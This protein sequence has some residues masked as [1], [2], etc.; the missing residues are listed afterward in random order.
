[1]RFYPTKIHQK[2][3]CFLL[4]SFLVLL[5]CTKDSDLLR[6]A[7]LSDSIE[8][9]EEV[10]ETDTEETVTEETVTEEEIV[11]ESIESRTTSFPPINDAHFQSG[12]GFN[13]SIIRLEEDSRTSYLMFDLSQIEA[14]DGVITAATLQF[15]INSDD[16]NGNITVHKGA[17]NDWTEENLVLSSIPASEEELGSITKEY[18]IGAT[19]GIELSASFLSTDINTLILDHKNGND[20]AI[21]SKEHSTASGPKLVVS[22]EVAPGAI[23]IVP[24]DEDEES[25]DETQEEVTAS[26]N[27]APM[28]IADGTPTTGK[29]PLEVSFT[30]GNSSDDSEVSSYTWNFK[31]GSSATTANPKHTFNEIGSY[32]V[33]L[34]VT[35][36]EGLTNTDTVLITVTDEENEAPVAVIS[37]NPKSGS[38]PLEVS[39]N[40][41]E[42]NDDN[43]ISSFEWDF[44]DGSTSNTTSPQHT[45]T[46]AGTY[47]VELTI[48]DEN[49]LADQ[50]DITITVTEPENEKPVAR[51]SANRTS[52]QAPLTVQFTGSNSTDDK[53][54][55]EYTWNFKN[56][57]NSAN[58]NPSHT[59][60]A[61]G[62][63]A[64]ALTV[65]DTEGLTDTKNITIT[66]SAATSNN[67]AP[68]AI[69]TSNVTSG[70]APLAVN[71]Q[72]DQSTDDDDIVSYVWNFDD[73]SAT[74]TQ[75]NPTHTF[76]SPGT[77]RV[78]FT[79]TDTDGA[80]NT[81]VDTITVTEATNNG[82]NN[83]GGSGG[84]NGNYPNGVKASTFGF[85]AGDATEAFEDAINSNH[86]VIIIDKQSSDW[87]IQPTRF[88]HLSNKTIVFESGVT[89]RAK[90]G[91]YS[92]FKT[93]FNFVD[94]DNIT[95]EGYGATLRMNRAEYGQSEYRH[96]IR[97]ESCT[98][99]TIKGF[100]IKDAGGDGININ[101]SANGKDYSENI[102]IE[103]VVCDNNM[104]QGLSVVSGKDIYIRNST[105]SGS[106][107]Q[108]PESG[109]DLEPT[110]ADERLQ[111]I[112][113]T[114]CTF[115][116]NNFA[117]L[118]VGTHKL[119]SNSTPISIKVANCLFT[120]NAANANSAQIPTELRISS[121]VQGTNNV[122]G[123]VEFT[124]LTFNNTRGK[125]IHSQKPTNAY[126][127]KFSNC[128][129]KNLLLQRNEIPI[130]LEG[131]LGAPDLGGFDFGN[132]RLEYNRNQPFM[133]IRMPQGKQVKNISGNFTVKEPS[134]NP[135]EY[136]NSP[137][138]SNR[139]N[140][141]IN[142][143]HI[144]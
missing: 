73:G 140:V 97:I 18:K 141:N 65:K 118:I 32:E 12:K 66:V 123:S 14:I 53:K 31:D 39:F 87:I 5:S 49:G 3:L 114:N 69:S 105:F 72:G 1:M 35:D 102:T 95:V 54:V 19:E 16:G 119:D 110:Y 104:R 64:V 21:A 22:Y 96:A 112:N 47:E 126:S 137:N 42:S 81:D 82:S 107:G 52:G 84:G 71:F 108:A 103:D 45:F 9:I 36:N 116:D 138:S 78:S 6:D 38:A 75:T 58:S 129:A 121:G 127:V 74:S 2:F 80:T 20:L 11:D 132:F 24:E 88:W 57:S 135:L 83:D 124:G 67:E 76:E 90:S 50:K 91:A 28:A 134:D 60:D 93:M 56:G 7:V 128:V 115:K 109:I 100:T 41:S 143:N 144:N 13:Q 77:Y 68:K 15:T 94:S 131:K 59:F 26:E 40:G 106:N 43:G 133:T 120:N 37:A 85:R 44:K 139:V 101:R 86:S 34:T 70:E 4:V 29:A 62:T 48:K 55:E 142:V 117:G 89:L 23:E 51:V 63:Y 136:I 98:N 46:E 122:K 25:E 113:I 8:T 33:T 92:Q 17:S 125:I 79:V 30:G 99:L 10:Q 130:V 61:P 111:N 27:E